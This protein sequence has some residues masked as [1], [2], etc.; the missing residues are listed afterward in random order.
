MEAVFGNIWGFI[1]NEPEIRGVGWD[2]A[3]TRCLLSIPIPSRVLLWLQEIFPAVPQL[4]FGACP[5]EPSGRCWRD[6]EAGVWHLPGNWDRRGGTSG[7]GLGCG[8]GVVLGL[9][10]SLAPPGTISPLKLILALKCKKLGNVY[11]EN[12]S[13]P[14]RSCKV[15]RISLASSL[16]SGCPHGTWAHGSSSRRRVARGRLSGPGRFS[17]HG[18]EV[19]ES[20]EAWEASAGSAWCCWVCFLPQMRPCWVLWGCVLLLA[21]H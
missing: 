15:R 16:G 5:C 19:M 9:P 4:L 10:A 1:R 13:P 7:M 14:G 17:P 6:P 21:G 12:L 8:A 3:R 18:R 2:R 11:M 20:I